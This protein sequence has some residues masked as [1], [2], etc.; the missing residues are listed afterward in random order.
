MAVGQPSEQRGV[1]RKAEELEN[2]SINS[3]YHIR[4]SAADALRMEQ[5]IY[6]IRRSDHMHASYADALKMQ[7]QKDE[8]EIQVVEYDIQVQAESDIQ[9]QANIIEIP[10]DMENEIQ[11][12]YDDEFEVDDDIQVIHPL[13][14]NNEVE[15]IT[16]D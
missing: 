5:Q 15:I 16:I 9:V 1:K 4:R 3:V 2:C 14:L 12:E 13:D 11:F 8:A 7:K 6:C 10:F